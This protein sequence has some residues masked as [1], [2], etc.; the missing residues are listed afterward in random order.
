MAIYQENFINM[1]T[2]MFFYEQS[3]RTQTQKVT[4][5]V[6]T[7]Y[8]LVLKSVQRASW[9]RKCRGN[10]DNIFHFELNV[11]KDIKI[12]LHRIIIS[13]QSSRVNENFT[14]SHS[15]V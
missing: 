9:F 8:Q 7:Q 5:T 15:I 1:Q 14:K 3:R 12:M 10:Q 11:T 2:T 4:L 13:L 6:L